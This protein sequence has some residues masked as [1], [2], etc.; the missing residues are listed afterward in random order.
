MDKKNRKI[1]QLTGKV[2]V[3]GGVY[4][5]LQALQAIAQVAQK[6]VLILTIVFLLAI[7]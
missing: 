7:L 4:S 6:K 3:F 5:N 2:L 1:G